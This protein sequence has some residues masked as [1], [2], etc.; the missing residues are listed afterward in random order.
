M[1][2]GAHLVD[3]LVVHAGMTSSNIFGDDNWVRH[4]HRVL[5]FSD[6]SCHQKLHD[7]LSE[8]LAHT[9]NKPTKSLL[10][11]FCS[12][13]HVQSMLSQ[14][15]WDSR[16]VMYR[17]FAMFFIVISIWFHWIF[18]FLNISNA[19]PIKE[20]KIYFVLWMVG[21]I[22]FGRKPNEIAANQANWSN[23]PEESVV[24]RRTRVKDGVPYDRERSFGV[25]TIPPRLYKQLS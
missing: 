18:L 9:I 20:R 6:E 8:C 5:Y 14:L 16:Y 3:I 17:E 13:I 2:L 21:N 4:P 19:N 24:N 10:D 1:V 22:I 25:P 23:F 15:P 7:F 11:G 12:W